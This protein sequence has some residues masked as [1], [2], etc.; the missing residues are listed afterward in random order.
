MLLV[1]NGMII[2]DVCSWYIMVMI[3]NDGFSGQ[4]NGVMINNGCSACG[5]EKNQ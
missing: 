5:S 2:N 1:Y 4:I 3:I